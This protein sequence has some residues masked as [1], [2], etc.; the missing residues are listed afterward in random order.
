MNIL[1]IASPELLCANYSVFDK[2]QACEEIGE[3]ELSS[4]RCQSTMWL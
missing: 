4:E 2:R 3:V 1:P